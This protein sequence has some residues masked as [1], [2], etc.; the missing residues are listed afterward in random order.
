MSKHPIPS[1][2]ELTI[3]KGTV[4]L[5]SDTKNISNALCMRG[6]SNSNLFLKELFIFRLRTIT[7]LGFSNRNDLVLK[8]QF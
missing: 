4:G 1:Q 5:V 6:F 2:T 7:F 3:W 8:R